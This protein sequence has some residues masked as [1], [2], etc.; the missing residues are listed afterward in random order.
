[1]AIKGNTSFPMYFISSDYIVNVALKAKNSS[2]LYNHCNDLAYP[3]F[4]H[5]Y[6][7]LS[8]AVMYHATSFKI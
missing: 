5:L 6:S 7:H 1:M 3:G 8:S 2:S 4:A